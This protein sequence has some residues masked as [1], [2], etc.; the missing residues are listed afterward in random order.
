MRT[1]NTV[2]AVELSTYSYGSMNLML[3]N[4]T[5]QLAASPAYVLAVSLP[6]QLEELCLHSALSYLCHEFMSVHIDSL[7]A[8]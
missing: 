5:L 6:A 4:K 8:R 7:L 1:Y 2:Q 3:A